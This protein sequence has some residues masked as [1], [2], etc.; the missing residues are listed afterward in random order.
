MAVLTEPQ[1]I[2]VTRKRAFAVYRE[3]GSSAVFSVDTV[4][5]TA[6]LSGRLLVGRIEPFGAGTEVQF[7]GNRL[8]IPEYAGD[9]AD[10][11]DGDIWYNTSTG[12][13][14][15]RQGA[16]N[17][18]LFGDIATDPIWDAL[19][20]LVYGS[21]PDTGA[22]LA[23][24]TSD[25]RKF[26]RELSVAGV[27]QAP[28]WDTLLDADIPATLMRD[29]EHTALGDAAPH[30]AEAHNIFSAAHADTTG[31]AAPVDGDVI[32]GNV[33]PAWSKL[34]IS[35]PAANVRNVF[36]IDNG[37]L[38]PSWKI[39]LDGTAPTTIG[40]SDVAAAGTSL[41][42]AH[43]DHQHGS[44]ATFPA[45]AH[46]VLSATHGDS[47]AAAAVRGDVVVGIGV[48]PKW[49]RYALAVPA[50][51]V[52]NVFGVDNGEV[53][54]TWKAA[55]DGTAAA[56]VASSGA[57]GTS[58]I[59]A[60][61]DHAHRGV[62][63][64]NKLAD[65]TLYGAVTLS[66]GANITLTQVGQDIAIAA[67]AGGGAHNIFS[68]THSDTTGAASPVDGDIIIGNVTPAWS[69]L[70]ISIPAANV[71]NVLGIDNA[72]L[73]P[74]WKTALDGTAPTTIGVSDVAAA[75]T[76][77]VFSHRDHQHGSPATFPATAHNLF[78][79]THGD[80]TGAASPVDG[81][82]II[83]NVTPA[84]SKL[85]IS[86][87]AANVLN[88]LGIANA[89]LR[90]SWKT[91]LD[92]T[93]PADIAAAAGPGTSL[94]FSHRDH[95]HAHPDLGDLHTVY[96]LA[97][98]VRDITGSFDIEKAA[99]V[100]FTG[101][102]TGEANPRMQ[103]QTDRLEFGAGGASA[104]DVNLYR[105]SANVLKT[106]DSFIANQVTS[107]TQ[108]RTTEIASPGATAANNLDI[109]A[110]DV[111]GVTALAFVDAAGVETTFLA[112]TRIIPITL[113]DV[114]AVALP[115]VDIHGSF[116]ADPHL[117]MG[118]G[119]TTTLK[120]WAGVPVPADYVAGTQMTLKIMWSNGSNAGTVNLTRLVRG[121]GDGASAA[122]TYVNNASSVAVPG[123][124]N[125]MG[126][127][128]LALSTANPTAGDIMFVS[129]VR[130]GAADSNNGTVVIW[131]VWLEYSAFF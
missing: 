67:A 93:N 6:A 60:H 94:V 38:R 115:D 84:W 73:R 57:A 25:T 55:L 7:G 20:D 62:L 47:T 14:R 96:F 102:V 15:G 111:G 8:G 39:A 109:Y 41:I 10:A 112:R 120:Q 90:P 29:A 3:G 23:G 28:V 99:G 75:G 117:D 21:G 97:S 50:A 27:A 87:P 74:S 104:L 91:A 40:I 65:T 58:L 70:A 100:L 114:A 52:R 19:G 69:K 121:Y 13:L 35:I 49:E 54:P 43:R 116:S 16:V 76:S 45:T 77:L 131:G 95:V 89:E 119:G 106:D 59:F 17:V 124:A 34:A 105:S 2:R 32:I 79:A 125:T 24:D 126:V 82:I 36:G 12:K 103:M 61:R 4:A 81:D 113:T 101:T 63:S 130:A 122:T 33:T 118:D 128:S 31:A 72:E 78:S 11:E 68:A 85:A 18:N 110:K 88:V 92:A 1:E 30:H 37:E 98:G 127:I 107:V 129:L 64:V 48:A 56:D 42:F 5:L 46:N 22:K 9:P 26:L 66:E 123:T 44:P 83:G 86:I 71:R 80:T 53:E 108:F 51:N